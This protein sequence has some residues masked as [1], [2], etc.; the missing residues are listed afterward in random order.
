MYLRVEPTKFRS[1]K[2]GI[3]FGSSSVNTDTKYLFKIFA[4]SWSHVVSAPFSAFKAPIVDL[5]LGLARTWLQKSLL[6]VS[7]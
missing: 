5:V 3:L 2:L 7:F 6:S 4:L 1:S